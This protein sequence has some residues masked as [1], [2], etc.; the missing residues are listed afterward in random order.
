MYVA[1]LGE[2]YWEERINSDEAF[3]E[4]AFRLLKRV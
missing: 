1:W 4:D 2:L 3:G